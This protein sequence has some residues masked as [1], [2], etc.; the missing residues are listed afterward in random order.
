MKQ[1][2]VHVLWLSYKKRYELCCKLSDLPFPFIFHIFY[3]KCSCPVLALHLRLLPVGSSGWRQSGGCR[4]S[5]QPAEVR[6]CCRVAADVCW[7]VLSAVWSRGCAGTESSGICCHSQ[8]LLCCAGNHGVHTGCPPALPASGFPLC[9]SHQWIRHT[10]CKVFLTGKNF[11]QSPPSPVHPVPGCTRQLDPFKW[12]TLNLVI[13]QR[14]KFR[15]YSSVFPGPCPVVFC[16]SVCSGW[17]VSGNWAVIMNHLK[18]HVKWQSTWQKLSQIWKFVLGVTTLGLKACLTP[19]VSG[20]D[21]PFTVSCCLGSRICR[22]C[23][24]KF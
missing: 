3:S 21:K 18:L 10:W 19:T 12:T 15:E 14:T 7:P 24:L 8:I 6:R 23:H 13:V 20:N 2:I 1:D 22:S 16:P 9:G 17:V 4:S 5:S 11:L